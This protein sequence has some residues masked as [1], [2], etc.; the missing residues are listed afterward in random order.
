MPLKLYLD[1]N[2]DVSVA[3]GLRSRGIDAVTARAMKS[4]LPWP[5][6]RGGSS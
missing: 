4:I 1:E 3:A 5:V 2:V 6:T